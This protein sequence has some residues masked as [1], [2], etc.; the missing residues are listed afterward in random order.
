MGGQQAWTSERSSHHRN[1]N[2]TY[3]SAGA[4]LNSP[5]LAR[6][7]KY[8][9]RTLQ[10]QGRTPVTPAPRIHHEANHQIEN[11]VSPFLG[12]NNYAFSRIPNNRFAEPQDSSNRSIVYRSPRFR[13]EEPESRWREPRG[14]HGLSFFDSPVF[15]G[16]QLNQNSK[17]D[18]S[19]RPSPSR[20]HQSRNVNTNEYI[21]KPEGG[22]SPFFRDSAYGSSR[23]RRVYSRQHHVQPKAAI[24]FPSSNRSA[25]SR[26]GQVPSAMPSIV[27]DR[28]PVRTQPQ[29]QGL[30]RMGVRSSRHDF[31]N[32][33]GDA[34][35]SS[36]RISFPGV[37]RCRVRR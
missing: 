16:T 10:L 7:D 28:S 32:I 12:N 17:G 23:E 37:G 25:Y 29:W 24:P 3:R 9:D 8:H 13:M 34:Y 19:D 1:P 35:A 11:V 27:S 4:R 21:V 22:R 33:A 20:R 5:S 30:Q 36:N 15:S 26:V 18:R 14:L 6:T 31:S 2:G